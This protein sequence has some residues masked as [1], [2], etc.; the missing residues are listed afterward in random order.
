MGKAQIMNPDIQL[1]VIACELDRKR[2][3]DKCL[4]MYDE[5]ERSKVRRSF[6][7]RFMDRMRGGLSGK[8]L[9]PVSRAQA[10]ESA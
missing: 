8:R 6:A 7:V 9:K 5:I 4:W 3:F 10:A 1:M 2:D